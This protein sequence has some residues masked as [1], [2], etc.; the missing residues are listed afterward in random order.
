MNI[1]DIYSVGI[2]DKEGIA[3]RTTYF[4]PGQK[5]YYFKRSNDINSYYI[6]LLGTQVILFIGY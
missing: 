1:I 5:S 2:L 6:I 3:D 4:K